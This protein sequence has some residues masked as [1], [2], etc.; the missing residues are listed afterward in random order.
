MTITFTNQTKQK[1][2][3]RARSAQRTRSRTAMTMLRRGSR[4]KTTSS[5]RRL[6]GRKR[7]DAG[8][9]SRG[10]DLLL[11]LNAGVDTLKDPARMALLLVRACASSAL[12]VEDD[13]TEPDTTAVTEPNADVVDAA[14]GAENEAGD[15]DEDAERLEEENDDDDDDVA[16]D[17]DDDGDDVDA[18]ANN[19]KKIA[20]ND[21]ERGGFEEELLARTD[22]EDDLEAIAAALEIAQ[23]IVE[24][25]KVKMLVKAGEQMD[26]NDDLERI[27]PIPIGEINLQ[28]RNST[29]VPGG[30]ST[31]AKKAGVPRVRACA[32]SNSQCGSCSKSFNAFHRSKNCKFTLTCAA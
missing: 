31:S 3:A 17:V 8:V 4:S 18:H 13:A 29:A 12:L 2:K 24:Q 26:E 15:E 32:I 21:D 1:G 19:K 16:D 14:T 23:A 30:S 9:D 22:V 11:A 25:L 27:S 20:T 6:K 7:S 5:M 10:G 28:R